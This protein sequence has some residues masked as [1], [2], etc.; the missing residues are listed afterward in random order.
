MITKMYSISLL[1]SVVVAFCPKHFANGSDV[2]GTNQS[3]RRFMADT[4]KHKIENSEQYRKEE[5]NGFL[6]T[7]KLPAISED[8]PLLPKKESVQKGI[9]PKRPKVS[10]E[11]LMKE[12]LDGEKHVKNHLN[13][14]GR[15]RGPDTETTEEHAKAPLYVKSKGEVPP[16]PAPK[17]GTGKTKSPPPSK[18][19]KRVKGKVKKEKVAKKLGKK[20]KGEKNIPSDFPSTSPTPT[21]PPAKGDV[22]LSPTLDSP[23]L[24]FGT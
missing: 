15:S 18:A 4:S 19:P 16:A 20:K 11:V 22:P 23:T 13:A 8:E 2:S 3:M 17:I 7:G 12:Y 1:L 14:T 24:D 6:K 5:L 21:M 10:T 9:A